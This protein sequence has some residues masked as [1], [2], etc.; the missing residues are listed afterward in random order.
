ME[1]SNF[2]TEEQFHNIRPRRFGLYLAPTRSHPLSCLPSEMLLVS[3]SYRRAYSSTRSSFKPPTT[4]SLSQPLMLSYPSLGGLRTPSCSLSL[5]AFD[6]SSYSNHLPS[7]SL[8][9]TP[10]A[11]SFSVMLAFGFR[12]AASLSWLVHF[13]L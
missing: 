2:V 6:V 3:L 4:F 11:L 5:L 1:A 10:R 8:F 9:L 7:L 12:P 13:P